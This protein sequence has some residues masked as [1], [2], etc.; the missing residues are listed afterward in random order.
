MVKQKPNGIK[1]TNNYGEKEMGTRLE[2]QAIKLFDYHRDIGF[3]TSDPAKQIA[4]LLEEVGEFVEAVMSG[5]KSNALMESGDVAWLL[6]D[7]LN[8]MDSDYLLAVGMGS[9]LEKLQKRHRS[10]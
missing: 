5:D 1:Q 2:D 8:V 10:I 7:I 4:K 6:V 9:S 3:T